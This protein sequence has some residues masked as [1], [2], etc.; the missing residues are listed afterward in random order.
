MHEE[1]GLSK[2]VACHRRLNSSK[3][4]LTKQVTYH[5][6]FDCTCIRSPLEYQRNLP[7]ILSGLNKYLFLP[8]ATI[9]DKAVATLTVLANDSPHGVVRWEQLTYVTTEP[10]GTDSTISLNILRQQGQ[11][12]HIRVAYM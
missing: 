6:R 2:Q 12:G 4:G 7:K 10:M 3:S 9:G 11:V 8:G 1:S 5:R